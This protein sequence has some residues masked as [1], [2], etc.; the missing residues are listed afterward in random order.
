MALGVAAEAVPV[1]VESFAVPVAVPVESLAVAVP[2]ESLA[3]AVPVAVESDGAAHMQ[4]GG[5]HVAAM[6][7]PYS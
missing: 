1:P 6:Q 5:K 7:D 2:V 3:V 4:W